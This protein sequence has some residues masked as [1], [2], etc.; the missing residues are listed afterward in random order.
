M[1]VRYAGEVEIRIQYERGSYHVRFT[2]P[3]L[4]GKGTLTPRECLLSQKDDRSSP[5]AYDK[6][7]R[8]VVGYLRA[9]GAR[10]GEVRRVFQAPCPISAKAMS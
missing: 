2:S 5:E 1:A 7:A 9:K 6:V 4:S 8:R 10:T 3:G